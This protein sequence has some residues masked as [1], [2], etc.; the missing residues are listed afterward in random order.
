MIVRLRETGENERKVINVPRD[1]RKNLRDPGAGPAM[2]TELKRRLHER[3]DFRGEKA[4]LLVKT[5][6]LLAVEF[7]EA[8]LVVPRI[9][10]AWAAVHEQ[11]D[12]GFGP[13][14]KM[15]W[16]R[17]ERIAGEWNRGVRASQQ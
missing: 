9:N 12:D 5:F 4:G 7:F 10:L 16:P 2:L 6:E 17:R 1:V 8:R 14:R 11:P 3:A 13:G 15:G